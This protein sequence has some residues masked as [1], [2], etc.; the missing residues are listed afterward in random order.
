MITKHTPLRTAVAAS[1]FALLAST[2]FVMPAHAEETTAESKKLEGY[3]VAILP[4]AFS[5]KEL[6]D[7]GQEVQ[8]LMTAYLTANPSLILV[9]RAEVDKALS[10]VELGMSGTVDPETAAKV[11]HLTGAQVLV[12]GRVFPVQDEIIMVAKIVG[13]ETGRVYGQTITFP[14]NGKITTA[15]QELS[16]KVGSDIASKG[17]TL[18]ASTE[19]KQDIIAKLKPKTEGKTLP[20]VSVTIDEKSINSETIDPAAETEIS[21]ILQQLG[22]EI[23]D[24]VK[25]N[26]KADIA[27]TGEAFSEF[28]L[29]KG[30]LVSAK[31]RIEIKLL[32]NS[33]NKVLLVDRQNS[34]AV[35]LAPEIA[36]KKALANGAT[37]LA[38]RS[39][40]TILDSL[41]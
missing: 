25:S 36:G 12:T 19:V 30:N 29:R 11:G 32:R 26:K 9:E 23:V 31:G 1:L 13:V 8:A 37:E 16:E 39:V 18:I 35:D 17:N 28:A 4:F 24:P 14:A 20:S 34:V 41:K 21:Y 7:M 27:I 2:A 15:A 10:E 33:D 40:E 3:T 22:F 5:G 6:E 38:G